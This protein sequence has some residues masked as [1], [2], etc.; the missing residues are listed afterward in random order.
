MTLVILTHEPQR[1]LN[2]NQVSYQGDQIN[3][4]FHSE[5]WSQG[6]P[7]SKCPWIDK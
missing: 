4:E 2:L 7:E 6:P 5:W 3:V 1:N